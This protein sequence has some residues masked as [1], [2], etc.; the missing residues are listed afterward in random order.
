MSIRMRRFGKKE[1]ARRGDAIY[2]NDVLPHLKPEDEG[3]FVALDIESGAFEIDDNE[4]EACDKLDARI[5]D[6]QTW[7][8]RIGSRYLHRFGTLETKCEVISYSVIFTNRTSSKDSR[9]VGCN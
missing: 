3:R 9:H 5:P 4:L 7:L 8:V 6:S 1:F 2:E